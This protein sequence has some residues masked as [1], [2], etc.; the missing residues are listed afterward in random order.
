[1]I[2]ASDFLLPQPPGTGTLS[3]H[4]LHG[5]FSD[6]PQWGSLTYSETWRFSS[7]FCFSS[8]FFDL[9]SVSAVQELGTRGLINMQNALTSQVSFS[10]V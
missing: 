7:D 10:C 3:P 1:M 9:H 5:L 6:D 2:S 8:S 4:S